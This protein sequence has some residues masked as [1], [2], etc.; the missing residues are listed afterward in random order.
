L[1][2][3]VLSFD[4]ALTI[5]TQRKKHLC[6]TINNNVRFAGDDDELTTKLAFSDQY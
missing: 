2:Q 1:L 3:C 5:E 4:K 6:G